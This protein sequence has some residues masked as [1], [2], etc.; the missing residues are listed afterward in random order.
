MCVCVLR[1]CRRGPR[2]LVSGCTQ[3]RQRSDYSGHQLAVLTTEFSVSQYLTA[4][5]R[6][7]LA[8]RL[9]LTET[10]VKVWYQN[11]RAKVK[12]QQRAAYYFGSETIH[13]PSLTLYNSQ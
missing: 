8:K 5:R 7:Y 13:A 10:Q 11:R 12:Q 9:S 4:E 6:A 1:G 3:H 2:K